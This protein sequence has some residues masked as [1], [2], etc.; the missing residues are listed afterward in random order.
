MQMIYAAGSRG[1]GTSGA[2]TSGAGTSGPGSAADEWPARLPAATD[3]ARALLESPLGGVVVAD[4]SG[5]V[6]HLNALAERASGWGSAEARGRAVAEVLRLVDA[7]AQTPVACPV[8]RVLAGAHPVRFGGALLVSRD[9]WQTPVQGSATVLGGSADP[10]GAVVVFQ[11]RTELSQ[12]ERHLAYHSR[13]DPLTGLVNRAAFERVLA[14]IEGAGGPG[15]HALLHIH[16]DRLAALNDALGR[17]AGD[18]QL[19]AITA[20]LERKARDGDV[21]ARLG[22]D[23]F[24]MLLRDLPREQAVALAREI[25]ADA[26]ALGE[27]PDGAGVCVGIA[28]LASRTA[29]PALLAAQAACEAA[30]ANGP[31]RVSVWHGRDGDA[32]DRQHAAHWVRRI[33]AAWRDRRFSFRLQEIRPLARRA[34]PLHY[35][36]L[37]RM[38]D[39]RGAEVMPGEFIL[40][41]ERYGL[42]PELDRW[43]IRAV[44]EMIGRS[45]GSVR[46]PGAIYCIN[47]SGASLGDPTLLDFIRDELARERVPPQSICFEITETA[48]VTNL[49]EAGALTRNLKALGCKLALDDFGAGLS[50]FAYLKS[51]AV[52]YLKIEGSFVRDM[53]SNRASRAIVEAINSLGHALGLRTIAECV[54]SRAT[55][56]ALREIGVDFAQGYGLSR[57]QPPDA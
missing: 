55:L 15:S 27:P 23:D 17:E 34:A 18:R 10:A 32:P 39:E 38:L 33:G 31:G 16:L 36:V 40:V 6:S 25:V 7:P 26:A 42:M 49:P 41:A 11:D 2:G 22:G 21:V 45:G 3:L 29:S 5:R 43:I 53:A 14:Q 37:L 9:G 47:L 13:H 24:G 57:P 44:L 4:R 56:A 35:E 48:A 54:E 8:E 50:S 19:R 28:A 51:L 1:A 52:D 12:L 46:V 30:R 20:L